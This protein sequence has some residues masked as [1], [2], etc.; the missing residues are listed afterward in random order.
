[1]APVVSY[2]T[3]LA[4]WTVAFSVIICGESNGSVVAMASTA[5]RAPDAA[6][7]N[8]TW[9]PTDA[10]GANRTQRKTATYA[11][12]RGDVGAA[13]PWIGSAV[14]VKLADRIANLR[15]CHREISSLLEMS[16][17]ESAS[18]RE[19]LYVVGMCEAMWAEHDR[20]T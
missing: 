16:R 18:F 15:A 11:R 17:R 9:K 2:L 20:L 12:M 3:S 6:G 10:P 19:A 5:V 7:W 14:Q 1:M 13:P 4:L 8:E